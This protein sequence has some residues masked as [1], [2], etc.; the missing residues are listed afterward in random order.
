MLHGG[1]RLKEGDAEEVTLESLLSGG[2][3]RHGG[4]PQSPLSA[5]GWRTFHN[6]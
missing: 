4:S 5:A 3:G 1:G 6:A 2:K